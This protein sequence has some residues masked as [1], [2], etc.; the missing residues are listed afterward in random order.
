MFFHLHQ[1][2]LLRKWNVLKSIQ[3]KREC[4]KFMFLMIFWFYHSSKYNCNCFYFSLLPLKDQFYL[5]AF[6]WDFWIMKQFE[7]SDHI[8][9]N[10]QLED[11][12]HSAISGH[13]RMNWIDAMLLMAVHRVPYVQHPLL[14]QKLTNC[15]TQSPNLPPIQKY[16]QNTSATCDQHRCKHNKYTNLLYCNEVPGVC[17]T[18]LHMVL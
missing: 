7:T 9:L 1:C 8:V 3:P 16:K 15:H 4:R 11:V 12:L 10:H 5:N 14:W 13:A 17:E 6:E 18:K 2:K